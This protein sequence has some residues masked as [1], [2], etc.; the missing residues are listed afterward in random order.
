[1]KVIVGLSSDNRQN[2]LGMLDAA[3]TKSAAVLEALSEVDLALLQLDEYEI[4]EVARAALTH[5]LRMIESHLRG[6]L[7]E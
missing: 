1:M 5:R 6:G 4:G 2:N 3:E 7:R